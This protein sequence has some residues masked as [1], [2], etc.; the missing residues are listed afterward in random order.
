[1]F[2]SDQ[3]KLPTK[4]RYTAQILRLTGWGSFWF[5]VVLGIVSSVIFLFAAILSPKG[6]AGNPALGGV[7]FLAVLSLFALCFT[8]YQSFTYTR[9]A[10]KLLDPEPNLRP[11]KTDTLA[12]IKRGLIANLVGMLLAVLG[13]EAITGVLL[14]K[15]IALS[16]GSIAILNPQNLQNII[17]PLDIFIV[18]ANTHTITAHFGGIVASLWLLDRLKSN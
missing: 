18:L 11:K 8:I 9:I 2:N 4:L 15:S 5:Q 14:G 6:A 1:M 17:Q 13:A 16:Q 3:S 12:Q 7:I 10:R